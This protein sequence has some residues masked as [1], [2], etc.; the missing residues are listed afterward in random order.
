MR[1][2]SHPR[3]DIP[4]SF[5]PFRIPVP[6]AAPARH[7]PFGIIR[8]TVTGL[9]PEL[10]SSLRPKQDRRPLLAAESGRVLRFVRRP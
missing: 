1:S 2:T 4:A 10:R 9:R 3:L 6:S 8:R 5:D 7:S